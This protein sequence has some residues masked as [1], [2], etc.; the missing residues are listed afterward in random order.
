VLG[1]KLAKDLRIRDFKGLILIRSANSTKS[2]MAT[3]LRTGAV[4]GCLGKDNGSKELVMDICAAFHQKREGGTSS[5]KLDQE[6]SNRGG[7][8]PVEEDF[9][10]QLFAAGAAYHSI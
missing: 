9:S 5:L 7:A 3:Y 6:L 2:D 10:S 1:T 4:D 8:V